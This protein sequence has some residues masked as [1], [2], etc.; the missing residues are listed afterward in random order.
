MNGLIGI[1]IAVQL[2]ASQKV[3][4]NINFEMI[5]MESVF[6]EEEVLSKGLVTEWFYRTY[7]GQA[8]K[9]LWSVTEEKWLTDWMDC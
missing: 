9:R 2:F 8:Q 7:N 1:L 5:Q 3:T 4:T 6:V